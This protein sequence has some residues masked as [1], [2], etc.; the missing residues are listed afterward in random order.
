MLFSASLILFITAVVYLL[1]WDKHN[2]YE[3]T[4]FFEVVSML[5]MIVSVA[6]AHT[7]ARDPNEGHLGSRHCAAIGKSL[8]SAS[9]QN[10]LV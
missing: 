3:W 4:V 10:I 2:L 7:V 6:V 1:L 9:L 5:F 8:F